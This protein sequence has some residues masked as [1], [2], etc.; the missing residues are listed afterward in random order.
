MQPS[1][2]GLLAEENLHILH[3]LF[4][5][6]V[7]FFEKLERLLGCYRHSGE[8]KVLNVHPKKEF[9]RRTYSRVLRF[10]TGL[11]EVI[12][13]WQIN[14]MNL[15]ARSRNLHIK[16]QDSL[17]SARWSAEESPISRDSSN[18]RRTV[19]MGGCKFFLWCVDDLWTILLEECGR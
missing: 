19:T 15:F 16:P 11:G 2:R 14:E 4:C 6:F 12:S 10:E 13:N 18:F 17:L 8:F 3:E 9:H 1:G 7:F 5:V